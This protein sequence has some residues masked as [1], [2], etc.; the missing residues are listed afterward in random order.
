[1][2]LDEAGSSKG[3]LIL[4]LRRMNRAVTVSNRAM[5][6]YLGIKESDFAV[7]D[8]LS[9]EGPQTPTELSH[10]LGIHPATMTGILSRLERDGRVERRPADADRRSIQIHAAGTERLTVRFE[11]VNEQ[12]ANLVSDLSTSQVESLASLLVSVAQ[13]TQDSA[14]ELLADMKDT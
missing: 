12:I 5:G 14:L 8:L 2:V 6:A 9:Q 3:R 11:P 13:V 1:M 4:A 7:L 10:S